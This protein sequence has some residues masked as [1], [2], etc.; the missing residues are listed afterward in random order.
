[1]QNN[2]RANR[3]LLNDD[4]HGGS[5]TQHQNDDPYNFHVRDSEHNK[6]RRELQSLKPIRFSKYAEFSP[7]HSLSVNILTV[8]IDELH[9]LHMK[10]LFAPY[11]LDGK[12]R[13]KCD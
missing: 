4:E 5:L 13:I 10:A 6:Y 3:K 9:F 8:G 12:T 2:A 1:M 7:N 11:R